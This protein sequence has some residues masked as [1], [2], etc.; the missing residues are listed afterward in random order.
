MSTF[1][2]VQQDL[3]DAN[4]TI[5]A[6][7]AQMEFLTADEPVIGMFTGAGYGKTRVLCWRGTI[8]HTKQDFW[9]EKCDDWRANPLHFIYGAPT[10]RYIVDRLAPEQR[11][12]V[13]RWEHEIGRKLTKPTGRARDGYFDSAQKRRLEMSNG[14]TFHFHGLDKE[15]SAV[16]TDAAGLYVDEA[17]MMLVQGIWTRATMRV[18]DPRAL[19]KTIAC[20]G[21]PELG[22]FLREEFFDSLTGK[23][24]EGYRVFEDATLN[25]P[26]I[27]LN[28]FKRYRNVNEVFVNMQVFGKW[29]QGAGGERFAHLFRPEMHLKPISI[30]YQQPGAVFDIGWDPGYAT[31][32]VVIMYYKPSID[33]W[34]VVHEIPIVNEDTRTIARRVRELGLHARFGNIRMIGLDPND[35]KK[36]KS[37]G[38]VTDAQIIYEELGIRPKYYDVHGFNA[39]LRTRNDVLA[40]MLADGRIVFNANMAPN[41]RR[42]P[43]VINS[44][45]NYALKPA[46]KEDD[47]K[48]LDKP[49]AST[50]KLWKHAVDAIHYVLMHHETAVYRR[51][52]MGV[53]RDRIEARRAAQRSN[54]ANKGASR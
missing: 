41:H 8:D 51:V 49:T 1:D 17:T 36:R 22:H 32:Q 16:A 52:R 2:I 15:G 47:A 19:S 25:N 29:E 3:L 21:T 4:C 11:A 40:T 30:S 44:I 35:A 10:S 39:E 31:G 50:V 12:V 7:P 24:R 46:D 5:D 53:D 26:V 45:L 6:W 37:N 18:R 54:R 42:Q 33:K 23:V 14:V 38:S 48:F 13:A 20:T 9:W 43:G 27:D 34:L 28:F